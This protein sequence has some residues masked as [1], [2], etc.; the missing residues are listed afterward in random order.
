[1]RDKLIHFYFG[2]D[3]RLVW[4]AIKERF[5]ILSPALENVLKSLDRS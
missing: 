5:P 1:M 3:Y 4:T 2:V